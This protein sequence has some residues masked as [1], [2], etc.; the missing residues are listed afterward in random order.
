M[1]AVWIPK[2]GRADVLEVRETPDPEPGEGEV[3]IRVEAAGLN[4]AEVSARQGLYPDAPK[5]PCVVGYEG[6]GVVD[7]VGAGVESLSVGER[8]LYLSRFWGHASAVCVPESFAARIPDDMSLEHAAALPVNYLTAWHM[9]HAVRRIQ[10]GERVLVHA[11]A[12]GVGTAVLQL[13]RQVE[14]VVTFGTASAAKHDYVREQGCHHP[15]DYRT[16]DYEEAV[17]EL[18]DGEGVDLVLDARGGSDWHKGYSLLREA[19]MLI[20]FGMANAQTGGKRNLLHALGT[21]LRNP[22]FKPMDMMWDNR[23]VAG[24]NLGTLWHR[25]DMLSQHLASLL[26]A[27]ER[28]HIAPQIDAT[29]P[30]AQ[31][32]QAHLRI[33]NRENRGKILL[34]PQ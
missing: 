34:T 3:R 10:P 15:I 4:F 20:A 2:H 22:R 27:Y 19:G 24:V 26:D 6:A 16:Q 32:A 28:G 25:H 23:A 17:R 18:T 13:C 11:A 30:F 9:L 8:V 21:L 33:E 5:P 7:A 12:G 29:F 31:A 1:R 14:G